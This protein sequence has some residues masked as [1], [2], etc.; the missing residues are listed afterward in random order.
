M[1]EGFGTHLARIQAKALE[2]AMQDDD[3][4]EAA[5]LLRDTDRRDEAKEMFL[6]AARQAE[7]QGNLYRAGVSLFNAED[8][9]GAFAMYL[10]AMHQADERGEYARAIQCLIDASALSPTPD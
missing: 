10:R 1:V 8:W 3:L 2:K 5:T 9:D 6:R 4:Y 7:E